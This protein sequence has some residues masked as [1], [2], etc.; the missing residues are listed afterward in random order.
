MVLGRV[1]YAESLKLKRTIA[2]KVVMLAPVAVILLT[3]FMASQAPFATLRRNS[4]ADEWGALARVNFQVWGLLMLPS[5]LTLQTA[6][7]AGLDHSE[8]QWKALLAR[9]VPRWTVYIAKLLV[10]IAMLVASTAV[11]ASGVL[12]E[13]AILHQ[14]DLESRFGFPVPIGRIFQKAAQMT[15][16]AFLYLTVQHWVSLRWRSF[17]VAIGFGIIAMITGFS[18]LLTAGQYGTWPQYFPWSLPM[19]VLAK[20]A[21]NIQAA[22][23]ISIAI[24]I[25]V[26]AAGCA[27]FCRREIT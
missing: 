8:N 6:L 18:M 22:I 21:Q 24:A 1:I 7:I 3:L 14:F 25:M 27:D 15:V 16:L 5:Y 19:L 17:S 4:T 26:A 12:L 11:L 2:L 10:V 13:G 9:P 20:Q 23:W